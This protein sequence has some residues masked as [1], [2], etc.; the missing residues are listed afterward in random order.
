[1]DPSRSGAVLA[2][3]AD[4]DKETGQL[5]GDEEGK[6]RRLV[7]S[8]DFHAVYQSAVKKADGLVNLYC[9]AHARRHIVRAGDAN[10]AQLGHWVKDWLERIRALYAARRQLTAAWQ[11]AGPLDDALAAWDEAISVIGTARTE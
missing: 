4:I 11:D 8:S 10:P 2:A 3:H 6:P 1:M 9:R 7:V 5:A